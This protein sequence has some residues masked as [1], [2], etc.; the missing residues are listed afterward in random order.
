MLEYGAGSL[1]QLKSFLAEIAEFQSYDI[2][3]EW[4]GGVIGANRNMTMMYYH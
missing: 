2:L 1:K 4:F 3:V